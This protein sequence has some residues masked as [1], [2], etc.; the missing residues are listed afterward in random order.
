MKTILTSII[1]ALG[2][3]STAPAFAQAASQAQ[4]AAAMATVKVNGL[5]CDFCVQ[6]L[7]KTFKKQAAVK[8]FHVDLDAKELHIGFVAGKSLDD[9]TIKSL[10]TDAGYNVVGIARSGGPA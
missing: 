1:L 3:V 7:T 8:S 2:A 5:V 6:A 10:V 4:P 9:A